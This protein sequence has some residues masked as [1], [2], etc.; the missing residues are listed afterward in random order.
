MRIDG[1]PVPRDVMEG[2]WRWEE[3]NLRHGAYETPALPLS[4]TA[5]ASDMVGPASTSVKQRA[6]DL[7][8]IGDE[9]ARALVGPTPML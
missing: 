5:R 8:G 3:L 7:N 1:P 9:G 4:Y 6:L 2:W